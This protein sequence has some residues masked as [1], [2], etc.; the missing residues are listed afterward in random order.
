MSIN[1][2]TKYAKNIAQA[3]THE[4]FLAGKAKAP[5][6]FVG[7][8]SVRIYTLLSQPL[9]DYDR[10]NA[11]NRYGALA[12]LQDSVQE[13]SMT[14]DKSFR[15]AIDKGNNQEQ[16]MVKEAGRVMKMQIR[17]QVVPTGDK[18]AL[19]QWAWGAGRCV[20]Y[21]AA[22]SKSNI[23]GTLLDMETKFMDSFTPIDERYVVVKNEH[24]KFIK[25]SDEFQYVDG[26][27]E[28]FIMKGVVGKIGTLNV[29]A[30][31][32][33]W[34][35]TNVEHIA[36]HSRAV[37][38]PFKIRDSRI[39]TDSEAV[40]GAVLLGRFLFDAFVVGGVCD[41]VIVAVSTGNKCANPAVAK[42][43]NTTITS[44]TSGAKI[45]YTLD[46]SDPR[47]SMSRVEYS[48]GITNPTAGTVLKAVAIYPTGN[49]Y[50]SDVVTH[51][52]A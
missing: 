14:Q 20:E 10:N 25:L 42:S 1:L 31:P 3:H 45:Y 32:A 6:D 9:N 46:G 33:A 4:S 22:V 12:E 2:A 52:C 51:I 21:G 15:I 16:E 38:M 39:I 17:E 47:Y 8:K 29:I 5:Y 28:N 18:R 13:I 30:M 43:S 49:K 37:G 36:F 11:N 44:A 40:N 35:P 27:R 41:D 34:F 19:Y 48:A 50:V 7:A 24:M 23:I 26:V